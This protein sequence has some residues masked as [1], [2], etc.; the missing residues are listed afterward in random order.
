MTTPIIT[1]IFVG[2]VLGIILIIVG[3]AIIYN[4]YTSKNVYKVKIK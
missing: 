4:A 3:I 2:W 1:V